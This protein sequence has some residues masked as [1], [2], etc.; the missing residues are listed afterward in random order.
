[1]ES[2]LNGRRREPSRLALQLAEAFAPCAHWSQV[3]V[4]RAG[5]RR[6]RVI[7]D[8]DLPVAAPAAEAP[9]DWAA[10]TP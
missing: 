5:G 9:F 7:V 8:T 10:G 3:R 1:M 2:K 6:T 4:Q